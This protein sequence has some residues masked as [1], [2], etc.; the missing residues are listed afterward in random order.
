M[1]TARLRWDL[2]ELIEVKRPVERAQLN[3]SVPLSVWTR[4]CF[5]ALISDVGH[6]RNP[7][8]RESTHLSPCWA[9]PGQSWVWSGRWSRCS[10]PAGPRVSPKSSS[11]LGL[12]RA[13][14][15]REKNET[16]SA[17]IETH[18]DSWNDFLFLNWIMYCGLLPRDYR[19]I[20]AHSYVYL[21]QYVYWARAPSNEQKA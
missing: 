15:N 14:D 2:P 1:S 20:W 21:T 8:L 5:L 6:E 17:E 4:R 13:K 16:G 7:R 3:C 9:P 18:S 12:G 10:T 19:L 11:P